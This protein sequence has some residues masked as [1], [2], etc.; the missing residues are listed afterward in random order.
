VSF[1][2]QPSANKFNELFDVKLRFKLRVDYDNLFFLQA[3]HPHEEFSI[4]WPTNDPDEVWR[5]FD[6]AKR[7][8]SEFL[9][10]AQLRSR[11]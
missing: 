9:D 4:G 3:D 11:L 5:F 8:G 1:A 6:V 7:L 10:M 2:D